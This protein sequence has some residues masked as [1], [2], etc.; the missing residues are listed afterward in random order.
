MHHRQQITI[1]ILPRNFVI[2]E[3]FSRW[4][5]FTLSGHTVLVR[6]V[7]IVSHY[8]VVFEI[9]LEEK[10]IILPRHAII[11]KEFVH[12]GINATPI[13]QIE[14]EKSFGVHD[15]RRLDGAGVF[16]VKI[17]RRFALNKN[18]IGADLENLAHGQDVGFD[19]MSKRR[20]EG[21]IVVQFL[22]PPA[23]RCGEVRADKHFVD[24]GVQL[25][26]G[27]PLGKSARVLCEQFGEIRVLKISNSIRHT[28]V[29]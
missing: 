18:R 17:F 11:H 20:H 9:G 7:I 1:V 4:I 5:H 8:A 24:W 23:Q 28:K 27:K 2:P 22:V 19:D 15:F 26:P 3:D 14:R 16:R 13:I 12:L 25:D 29:T 6:D 10:V 21:A